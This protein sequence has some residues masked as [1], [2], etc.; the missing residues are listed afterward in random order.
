MLNVEHVREL[1]EQSQARDAKRYA[2]LRHLLLLASGA[3]TLL[4]SLKT[5]TSTSSLALWSLRLAWCTLGLG[6]LALGIALHG[7]VWTA[8]ALV[9]RRG[10]TIAKQ[11]YADA[12]TVV[13]KPAIYRYSEQIAYAALATTV[14]ALACHGLARTCS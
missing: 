4:V 13:R 6:I 14:L 11:G 1:I 8:D 2:W 10:A 12:P 5:D 9:K 7:E 3:L